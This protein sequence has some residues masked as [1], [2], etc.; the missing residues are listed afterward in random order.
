MYHHNSFH[1]KDLY[2]F[3]AK[4]FF[5]VTLLPFHFHLFIFIDKFPKLRKDPVVDIALVGKR[6]R[7]TCT[8]DTIEKSRGDTRYEIEFFEGTVTRNGKLG[9]SLGTKTLKGNETVAFIENSDNNKLFELSNEVGQQV[10]F[11]TN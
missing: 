7:I 1:K 4:Y 9:K 2:L 3:F 6:I 5:S 11:L 8:I 10:L